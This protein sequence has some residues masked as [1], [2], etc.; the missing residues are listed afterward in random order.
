MRAAAAAVSALA[1][2]G[3]A[4]F[5]YGL[6]EASRFVIRRVELPVLPAGAADIRVLHVSDLH[7]L[8][9][10]HRKIEFVRRLA[11][12]EPDLVVNT[13]DNIASAD[14]IPVL[15]AA[16]GRLRHVPGVFVFGSNDY[17]APRFKNPLRY[18]THGRS[19]L[20]PEDL[21]PTLPTEELRERLVSGGWVDLT[22]RRHELQIGGLRIEFRGT[23]DAHHGHDDYRLVEGPP[24]PDADLAIGVTHA[25]Y[26]RILDAMT[27][28]GVDLVFAGH[29]HGGQVCVPGYGAL[30]TNCDLDTARVKGPSR[31]EHAGRTAALHVSAGLGTSPYAP[32]R[33]ACRPEVSLVTLRAAH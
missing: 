20:G 14:A 1:A 13:G 25:P 32:F 26:L 31:H 15:H 30:T 3:I 33:F 21:P 2:T 10:Q 19:E 8:P 12:L 27:A 24:A 23:D 4:C 7:L 28:D 29:T 5:G 9:G 18:V 16:W 6:L 22:H 17:Q 11:D